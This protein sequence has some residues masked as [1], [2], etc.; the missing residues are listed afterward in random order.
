VAANAARISHVG[1][2]FARL[3]HRNFT[4]IGG[5]IGGIRVIRGR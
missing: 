5:G 3:S 4:G 1:G 2:G